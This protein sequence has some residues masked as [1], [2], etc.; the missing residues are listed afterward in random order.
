MKV[1]FFDRL[2][3]NSLDLTKWAQ[4]PVPYATEILTEQNGHLEQTNPGTPQGVIGPAAQELIGKEFIWKMAAGTASGVAYGLLHFPSSIGSW[5]RIYLNVGG[6][7]WGWAVQGQHSTTWDITPPAP[8]Q[9]QVYTCKIKIVAAN[10]IEFYIDGVRYHNYTDSSVDSTVG[11]IVLSS[12]DGGEFNDA[13]IRES[14]VNTYETSSYQIHF[15]PA[16]GWFYTNTKPEFSPGTFSL[17]VWLKPDRLPSPGETQT[18]FTSYDVL[19][20]ISIQRD[21]VD[22]KLYLHLLLPGENSCDWEITDL[23]SENEWFHLVVVNNASTANAY[24]N[25]IPQGEKGCLGVGTSPS[26]IQFSGEDWS[27][28]VNCFC[29]C[30]DEAALWGS[31]LSAEDVSYSYNDGLGKYGF[32]D[33]NLLYG[34]HFKEGEGTTAGAYKGHSGGNLHGDYTW[35]SGERANP[36]SSYALHTTAA[37]IN[38]GIGTPCQSG[39][40]SLDLWL[41]LDSL[42]ASGEEMWIFNRDFTFKIYITRDAAQ[43][44]ELFFKVSES[45]G[46][47]YS[48]E[49][50]IEGLISAEQYHHIVITRGSGTAN[51]YIDNQAQTPISS[52]EAGSAGTT[53][54]VSLLSKHFDDFSNPVVGTV[55]EIRY[56]YNSKIPAEDVAT[57]YNSGMGNYSI[58]TREPNWAS[59]FNN[60]NGTTVDYSYGWAGGL[61]GDY[62]WVN[63][64]KANP[65]VEDET[66][67]QLHFREGN[68]SW[69]SGY[70]LQSY[71]LD[72]WFK[73]DYLPIVDQTMTIISD[74][75]FLVN[76]HRNI[77]G[78]KLVF[79]VQDH[80]NYEWNIEEFITTGEWFHLVFVLDNLEAK[81]YINNIKLETLTRT[82]WLPLL[83]SPY[84]GSNP[85]FSD[86]FVGVIDEL[87]IYSRSLTENQVKSS[88]NEGEGKYGTFTPGDSFFR[89]GLH[90]NEGTGGSSESYAYSEVTPTISGIVLWEPGIKAM[91]E[92]VGIDFQLNLTAGYV[93]CGN[94]TSLQISPSSFSYLMWVKPNHTVTPDLI[95]S[96]INPAGLQGF[97]IVLLPGNPTQLGIYLDGV[98]ITADLV[99]SLEIGKWNFVGIT[100]DGLKLRFYSNGIQTDEL[101]YTP[102]IANTTQNFCIGDI[103]LAPYIGSLDGVRAYNIPLGLEQIITL[104][105]Y[106]LGKHGAPETG[107]MGCW[108]FD[109]GTGPTAADSSGHGNTGTLSSEETITWS[110]GEIANS[111]E[112]RVLFFDDFSDNSLDPTNWT[113]M[114]P[115]ATYEFTEQNYRWEHDSNDATTGDLLYSTGFNV[116][117]AVDSLVFETTI[118]VSS[119][120]ANNG[121]DMLFIADYGG[122]FI[123]LGANQNAFSYMCG[124][125]SLQ[126]DWDS[127]PPDYT[128]NRAYQL[129]IKIAS[130]GSKV[131]YYIDN[132]LVKTKASPNVS[133]TKYGA[134]FAT[135]AVTPGEVQVYFHYLRVSDYWTPAPIPSGRRYDAEYIFFFWN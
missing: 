33:A 106:G 84:V 43:E 32:D 7:S 38:L 24:I 50:N 12:Q 42:P 31:A 11:R 28:P 47:A 89:I 119:N 91:P 30:M 108:D 3:N 90:F 52:A 116:S 77:D 34:I 4:A 9:D 82:G 122:Y 21:E 83:G 86:P 35:E 132:I 112:R 115:L 51:L 72:G 22:S 96:K 107:L 71:S 99:P 130:D 128:G 123:A 129:K 26:W 85:D 36:A 13:F 40:F 25:N 64:W 56:Y 37:C 88:Y 20:K 131:E 113:L 76:F 57:S 27:D 100:G 105:N 49:W 80:D 53:N 97:A 135:S 60:G 68:I 104:Y 18:I 78:E 101:D 5:I 29:G 124:A 103:G 134:L 73:F 114:A 81:L 92:P 59:H 87:Q 6:N 74:E 65:P 75:T 70:S 118:Y 79:K 2:D 95:L 10:Q 54:H 94:D 93:N 39:T 23:V 16:G 17:D 111:E 41:S 55:D 15:G 45:E 69:S 62:R 125:Y 44:D 46:E 121:T 14:N 1:T 48:V 8:V 61:Y 67:C 98:P 127:D 19:C 110:E 109:E 63:G 102:G 120:S 126:N 58:G 66:S 133:M 117:D